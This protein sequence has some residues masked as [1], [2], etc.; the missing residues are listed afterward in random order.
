MA[1]RKSK[2]ERKTNET[3]I[4]VELNLDGEGCYEIDTGV[5]F[6]DH[7]LTHLSKHSKINMIIKAT[8]DLEIDAHHT[9]EDIGICL[10]EAL[11]AA[12]ADKKGIARYG[13]ST[14]PME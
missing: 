11:C 8:G 12:V 13:N 7:M 10:G 3:D 1:E 4:I 2:I 5:G 9:I 6:F 14:V